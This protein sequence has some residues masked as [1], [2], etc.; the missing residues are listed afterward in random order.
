[1]DNEMGGKNQRGFKPGVS[2]QRQPIMLGKHLASSEYGIDRPPDQGGPII[3]Q[4]KARNPHSNRPLNVQGRSQAGAHQYGGSWLEPAV[5]PKHGDQFHAM[6]I[7][8]L[9]RHHQKV[10]I[11]DVQV[12]QRLACELEMQVTLVAVVL[13]EPTDRDEVAP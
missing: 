7:R 4:Q 6:D 11:I 3:R 2:R 12:V 10:T 8:Q 5:S 1:M 13:Q 9:Q